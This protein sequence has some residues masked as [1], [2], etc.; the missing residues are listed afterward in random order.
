VVDYSLRLKRELDGRRLWLNAYS[1][2]AP[3]Y[4]PSERILKEGGYEGGGAMVYYDQPTKLAVGLERQIVDV[5]VRQVGAAVRPPVDPNQ[6]QGG[7]PGGA[8]EA[9][10]TIRTKP[11][12]TVELVAAEPLVASPVAIDFGPDAKVWVAEMA[13]YPLGLDGK[14]QPGGRVRLLEST[15]GD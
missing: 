1:N 2:D 9:V 3:C 8:E 5:V 12:L 15:A 14:Y 13:D 10:A 6:P 11:E 7:R 4:I